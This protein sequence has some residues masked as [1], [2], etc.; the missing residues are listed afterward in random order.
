MC[1]GE[2]ITERSLY[3]VILDLAK[4]ISN[5]VGIK[6]TGVSEVKVGDRYPDIILQLDSYKLLVQ[7]KINTLEKIKYN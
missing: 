4:H 5:K 3:P 1:A 7:V 6:V 2:S